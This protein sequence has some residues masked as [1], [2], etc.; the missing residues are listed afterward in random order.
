[1]TFKYFRNFKVFF[2]IGLYGLHFTTIQAHENINSSNKFLLTPIK[3][4]VTYVS[5]KENKSTITIKS[6]GI[7]DH[8]TGNFPSQGNPHTISAQ[9]H[10]L[11]IPKNPKKND[12]VTPSKFFGV[13]INGVMFVPE[14]IECWNPDKE[15]VSSKPNNNSFL[16][17][18]DKPFLL[19]RTEL[20]ANSNEVCKWRKEAI[21]GQK[22]YLGLDIN[23][24]H[25]QPNGMYHYHGIPSG[26]LKSQQSKN[27]IGDL[28]HVGFAGDGFKIFVSL[29]NKLK[30]SY[31]LKLGE[32]IGGPDGSHDGE[33]T[34]D[35]EFSYGAGQL[36]ECNGVTTDEYGYIYLIT[37]DF[38][39]VPRCWKGNP[40]QTFKTRP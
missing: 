19:K 37:N 40:D 15:K 8:E 18:A 9:R 2:F 12:F 23:N 22:K 25:V 39:F 30:S 24:A 20:Q 38:P 33:Y 10:I 4:K 31:K 6:N 16:R 28:V 1:M 11:R 14:T 21:V 32:R 3:N 27:H 5:F 26:L 13:A 29:E 17:K 34:Q 36:D 7:P 35:F